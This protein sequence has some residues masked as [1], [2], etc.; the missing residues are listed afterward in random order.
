MTRWRARTILLPADQPDVDPVAARVLTNYLAPGETVL[1]ARRPS[2][3]PWSLILRTPVVL[4]VVLGAMGAVTLATSRESDRIFGAVFVIAIAV[5][6][7]AIVVV[8]NFFI[9]R[10]VRRHTYYAISNWRAFSLTYLGNIPLFRFVVFKPGMPVTVRWRWRGR[11]WLRVGTMPGLL[12][13]YGLV[14][15]ML[16]QFVELPF[17]VLVQCTDADR[18]AAVAAAAIASR[19]PVSAPA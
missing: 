18:A 5:P 1:W 14:P 7:A 2:E 8:T 13:R 16:D 17:T 3:V 4:L 15:R 19:E 10:G 6:I 11:G 12:K 9:I